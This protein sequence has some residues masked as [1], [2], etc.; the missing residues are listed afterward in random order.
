MNRLPQIAIFASGSGSN[1]E[2]IVQ[3][4]KNSRTAKVSLIICNN[5]K[6]GV[7]DRARRL[8]IPLV[9]ISKRAYENSDL[10]LHT[11]LTEEIDFIVLAGFLW[12]IPNSVCSAFAQKMLNIHPSLLP[13]F[14]GKGMY[15]MN[16]HQAV[17]EAKEEES[18]ITIHWVNEFY[19]E[20]NIV[21][22]QKIE[23]KGCTDAEELANKIHEL[24][25]AFYPKVIEQ[26]I[27]KI[28]P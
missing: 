2:N 12:K 4:F 13:K 20:G 7:I 14:G 9:T 5:P 28:N 6:A 15:G 23:T 8:R 10:L 27:Q 26:E 11:L 3:Y 25:H 24:E 17:L 18:G 21:F 22:Q 19:D 1:A 16:V